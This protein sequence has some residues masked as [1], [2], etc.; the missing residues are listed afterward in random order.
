MTT[1]PGKKSVLLIDPKLQFEAAEGCSALG[2]TLLPVNAAF[3]STDLVPLLKYQA[4]LGKY[5]E[6]QQ[7][8]VASH[9]HTCQAVDINGHVS[10]TSCLKS[11][12][13]LCTQTAA[14]G[15]SVEPSTQLSVF[16]NGLTV[17]GYVKLTRLLSLLN[18]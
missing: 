18:T 12:P 4:F 17:T 15:A 2:E 7:F 5:P 13:A 10:S 6:S 3:F 11:L 14:F 9:G 1:A 8:W 16:S